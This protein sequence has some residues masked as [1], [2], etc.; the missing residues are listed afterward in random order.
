[1]TLSKTCKKCGYVGI[2]F[3]RHPRSKDGFRHKCRSC[4]SSEMKVI[5]QTKNGFLGKHHSEETKKHL[6]IT[7]KGRIWTSEQKVNQAAAQRRP[8]VRAAKS[9]PGSLNPMYGKPCPNP[10]G[11]GRSGY[12]TRADGRKVWLR[13]SWEK[14]V[15]EYLDAHSMRW[16]YEYRR[17]S[18]P[19]G[20]TYLPDF[21]LEDSGCYWEVKGWMSEGAKE[22]IS[23]YRTLPN[24]P[25]LVVINGAA[26]KLLGGNCV[27]V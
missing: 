5:A 1:M 17:F 16:E 21:W 9:R 4:F 22:K 12:Y 20:R 25:P 26:M 15:A 10:K 24:V 13:S 19:N 27:D 23:Q 7:Q 3:S 18:L 11:I 8:E 2:N 6:S 14:R